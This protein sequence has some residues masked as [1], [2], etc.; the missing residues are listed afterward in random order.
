MANASGTPGPVF[1]ACLQTPASRGTVAWRP[2]YAMLIERPV[3]ST[4]KFR[5]GMTITNLQWSTVSQTWNSTDLGTS[6]RF[7]L[8]TRIQGKHAY[9]ACCQICLHTIFTCPDCLLDDYV[10]CLQGVSSM[11]NIASALLHG[12][13]ALMLLIAGLLQAQ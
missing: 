2:F 3:T 6:I 9:T 7:Q 4:C 12:N 10:V 13:T 1:Q 11:M 8:R 5:P